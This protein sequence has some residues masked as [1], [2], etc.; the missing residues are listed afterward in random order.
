MKLALTGDGKLVPATTSTTTTS[1]KTV[2]SSS[3]A[4]KVALAATP[5]TPPAAAPP[6][7]TGLSGNA[8]DSALGFYGLPSD[9]QSEVD[10]IF[11]NTADVN[12]AT[13]LALAYIRGTNW[14]TQT[15]PGI[16]AGIS[17]GT[18]GNEGDYRNYVNQINQLTQQ[19]YGRQ[20]TSQDIQNFL[21]QGFS[22]GRVGQGFQG[23]AITQANSQD[24]RYLTGA[25]ANNG[26]FT[27]DQASALGNEQAGIDTTAGQLAQK[28]LAKA[29]QIQTKLFSGTLAT[30]S[31]SV[32]T[33]GLSSPSLQGNRAGSS[34]DVAA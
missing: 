12:A 32:G 14:Y 20:A 23:Q 13:A 17:N 33:N 25:Y 19:Y 2:T 18:V 34:P 8:A 22:V 1:E 9:V 26:P 6:T 11:A 30:P 7:G 28:V 31:L 15:Y 16:Q 27:T 10:Q 29:Q 4:G 21:G 5:K 24:W 3:S